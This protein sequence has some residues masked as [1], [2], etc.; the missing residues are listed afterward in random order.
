MNRR[1]GVSSSPASTG[2]SA[3][4]SKSASLPLRIAFAASLAAASRISF[5]FITSTFRPCSASWCLRTLSASMRRRGRSAAC[6]VGLFSEPGSPTTRPHRFPCS[7][8]PVSC[9]FAWIATRRPITDD[10]PVITAAAGK[11]GGHCIRSVV[12][13]SHR[14]KV[15]GIHASSKAITGASDVGNACGSGSS[16]FAGEGAGSSTT[17]T[18]L[19]GLVTGTASRTASFTSAK[20]STAPRSR[21]TSFQSLNPAGT[22]TRFISRTVSGISARHRASH[23]SAGGALPSAFGSSCCI[24]SSTDST[25]ISIVCMVGLMLVPRVTRKGLSSGS[26]RQPRANSSA[27]ASHWDS[28]TW[29]AFTLASAAAPMMSGAFFPGAYHAFGP[30]S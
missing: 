14:R 5:D 1:S 27:H 21:S 9:S 16:S 19:C 17:C 12:S 3:L 25:P 22:S 26:P 30:P 10:S 6:S 15:S 13:T 24:H 11:S 28:I 18:A 2:T 8:H 20:V 29:H 7:I 23:S 4:K